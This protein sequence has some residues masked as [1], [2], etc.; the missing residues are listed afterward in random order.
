MPWLD[1]GDVP[2]SFNR[3]KKE[4]FQ[5]YLTPSNDQPR[6][7]IVDFSEWNGKYSTRH[8][9]KYYHKYLFKDFGVELSHLLETIE[10]ANEIV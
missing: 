3:E 8:I 5:V 2:I 4:A 9:K 7:C 1:L 10:Q 6:S